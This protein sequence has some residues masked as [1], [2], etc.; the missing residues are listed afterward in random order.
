MVRKLTTIEKK[1]LKNSKNWKQVKCFATS[2]DNELTSKNLNKP[3]NL[4]NIAI[5]KS[6]PIYLPYGQQ[7]ITDTLINEK[8]FQI[9]KCSSRYF[10]EIHTMSFNAHNRHQLKVILWCKYH[11]CSVDIK[12]RTRTPYEC[13]CAS[14]GACQHKIKNDKG[15]NAAK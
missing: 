15:N 12:N 8:R 11:H 7:N 9:I 13:A 5:Q 4:T 14:A 6:E 10:T 2:N 1:S 3:V